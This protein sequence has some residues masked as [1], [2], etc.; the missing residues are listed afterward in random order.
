MS[1]K[2][3]H[4]V[5]PMRFYEPGGVIPTMCGKKRKRVTTDPKQV[6]CRACRLAAFKHELAP[7][8]WSFT[9]TW[10]YQPQAPVNM[11]KVNVTV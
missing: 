1:S 3:V 9:Y 4:K 10:T 2:P 5:K 11:I 6:T 7:E 8:D